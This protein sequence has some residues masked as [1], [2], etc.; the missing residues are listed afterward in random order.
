MH[1]TPGQV[2]HPVPDTGRRATG[3]PGTGSPLAAVV[4]M[5]AATV[6]L[7]PTA[8]LSADTSADPGSAAPGPRL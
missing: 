3:V 1:K 2:A 7:C 5:I 6:L 4:R 8:V